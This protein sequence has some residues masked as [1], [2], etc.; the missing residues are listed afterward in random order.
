MGRLRTYGYMH[1]RSKKLRAEE[2]EFQAVYAQVDARSEGRCEVVLD[3]ERCKRQATEH[4]HLMKPRRS[5]HAPW[6]IVHLCREHHD[7]TVW[8]FKRG[9]L[10]IHPVERP[11]S[12]YAIR[13]ASDKYEALDIERWQDQDARDHTAG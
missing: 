4:H 6:L 5:N 7:R 10:V 11:G 12:R 1:Q 8:P 9:R 3:G 2:P 13:F